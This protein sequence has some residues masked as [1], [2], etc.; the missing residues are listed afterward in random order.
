[1]GDDQYYYTGKAPINSRLMREIVCDED[2]QHDGLCYVATKPVPPEI[3]EQVREWLERRE[4]A[5]L[6]S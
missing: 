3:Q 1:M 6:K 2:H 4:D 5:G